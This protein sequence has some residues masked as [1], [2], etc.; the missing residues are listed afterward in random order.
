MPAGAMNATMKRKPPKISAPS[1]APSRRHER[2]V[3]D[4]V[5]QEL[6]FEVDNRE[7]DE[8][9]EEGRV[10]PNRERHSLAINEDRPQDTGGDLDPEVSR[11]DVRSAVAALT[12]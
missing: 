2:R 4:L 3:H 5:R 1:A 9:P 6:V 7:H 10:D 11:R 8:D 12:A